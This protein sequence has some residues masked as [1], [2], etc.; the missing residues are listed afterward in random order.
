MLLIIHRNQLFLCVLVFYVSVVEWTVNSFARFS[1]EFF[2]LAFSLFPVL[3]IEP[4]PLH[5][6]HSSLSLSYIPHSL[7]DF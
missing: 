1:V 7:P 2:L 3:G 5:V 6:R 4:G